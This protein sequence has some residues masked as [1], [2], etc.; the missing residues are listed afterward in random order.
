[1]L[2]LSMLILSMNSGVLCNHLSACNC[3]TQASSSL[4]KIL[5]LSM[6]ILSMNSGVLCNCFSACNCCT[7][8]SSSCFTDHCWHFEAWPFFDGT[9]KLDLSRSF[10]LL[11]IKCLNVTEILHRMASTIVTS[12]TPPQ[13]KLRL[14]LL[15]TLHQLKGIYISYDPF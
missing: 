5:R 7:Q 13:A 9:S 12:Y 4:P 1:M 8:A 14:Q 11:L 10:L 15:P 3:G 6:L 2:K